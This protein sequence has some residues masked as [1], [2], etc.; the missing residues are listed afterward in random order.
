MTPH[1]RVQM[2]LAQAETRADDP[3]AREH[4][5]A[6]RRALD[7]VGPTALGECPA[8]GQIGPRSR[9]RQPERHD[10]QA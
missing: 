1:E 9:M 2:Q 8:C 5:R 3:D 10:C 6:A 4:I 7:E